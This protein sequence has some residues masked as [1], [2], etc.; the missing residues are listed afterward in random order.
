MK[1]T[2]GFQC[3]NIK[4]W[5]SPETRF[6]QVSDQSEV[7]SGGNRPFKVSRCHAASFSL[8]VLMD[9]PLDDRHDRRRSLASHVRR[10]FVGRPVGRPSD[11]PSDVPSVGRPV[12]RPS[13]VRQ[14][15]VGRPSDVLRT[16]LGRPI[17]GTSHR[18]SL[19]RPSDIRRIDVR[20]T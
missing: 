16:S 13:D 20:W 7:S 8:A 14:T 11:G 19:A 9:R 15:P 6:G 2:I 17:R 18:T 4:C 10:T 5:G 1:K 12:G 3:R